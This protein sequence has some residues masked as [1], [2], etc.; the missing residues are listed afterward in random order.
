MTSYEKSDSA[1]WHYFI[2]IR[3]E[4][5]KP[6]AFLKRLPNRNNKKNNN[7]YILE[8]LLIQR[9]QSELRKLMFA[10]AQPPPALDAIATATKIWEFNYISQRQIKQVRGP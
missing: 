1:N 9:Q 2:T 10:F 6:Q 4:T 8:S 3:F 5:K 7:K